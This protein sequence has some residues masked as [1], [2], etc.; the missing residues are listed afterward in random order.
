MDNNIDIIKLEVLTDLIKNCL[1]KIMDKTAEYKDQNLIKETEK[2]YV[3]LGF[4]EDI[5]VKN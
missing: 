2:M 4:Q 5:L 1:I 3:L